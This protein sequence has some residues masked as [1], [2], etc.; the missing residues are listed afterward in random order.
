MTTRITRKHLEAIVSRLNTLCGT[1]H[2]SYT[3]DEDTGK[4]KANIGNFHLDD[5]HG[6]WALHQMANECGG[7]N[8]VF[9]VGHVPARALY[10]QIHAFLC[11]M[12]YAINKEGE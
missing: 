5:A 12:E 9:R 1:P 11:G 4:I 8:D 3:R 6:G 7:V 2:D 10:D